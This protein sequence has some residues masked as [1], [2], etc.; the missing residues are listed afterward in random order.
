MEL[1][2]RRALIITGFANLAGALLFAP[3]YPTL[4]A[5][6]GL[7]PA[8]Q[9]FDAWLVSWW[10]LCFGL[11]YL[12]LGFSRRNE[13]LF[14][15]VAAAG[16]LSLVVLL[17][18]IWQQGTIGAPAALAGIPDLVFAAIFLAWLARRT[19]VGREATDSSTGP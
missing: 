12:R 19:G 11:A 14:V 4:R 17:I 18:V 13:P 8:T 2:F 6:V 3:L 1:L 15:A 9:P 16:K 7:P 10:T 5:Q